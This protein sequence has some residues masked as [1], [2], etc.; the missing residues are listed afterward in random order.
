M[1]SAQVA[2]RLGAARSDVKR[3]CDL[4]IAP[5]PEALNRCQDALQRAVS[6]LMA[7]RAE[8][9]AMIAP[10]LRADLRADV[11]R[12]RQLLQNLAS[13]YRGWERILGTMS[14]GYTCGGSPAPVNRQGRICCRG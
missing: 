13:F 1:P 10:D 6:E 11:R 7:V 14:G 12:V 9:G 2:E 3:A 4:L 8:G 5:T